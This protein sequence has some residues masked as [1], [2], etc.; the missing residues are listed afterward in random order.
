[1][2]V[3]LRCEEKCVVCVCVTC[4][5]VCLRCEEEC[6]VCVC[7]WCGPV[8]V[9]AHRGASEPRPGVCGG[10]GARRD[11]TCLTHLCFVLP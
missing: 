11:L 2:C 7:V 9:C 8:C 1:M 3:Y 10:L 6:E 4:V 5:C